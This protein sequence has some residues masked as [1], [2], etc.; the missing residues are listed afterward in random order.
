MPNYCI[1]K[2]F[3]TKCGIKRILYDRWKIFLIFRNSIAKSTTNQEYILLRLH[4]YL[5][6]RVED[7]NVALFL[8]SD[9]TLARGD[10]QVVVEGYN[11]PE[12]LKYLKIVS[13]QN[14]N[15]FCFEATRN[16]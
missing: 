13:V 2:T 4:L 16:C 5:L 8:Q 3:E 10:V 14:I 6:D 1:I 11:I 15:S 7:C 9:V 12:Y